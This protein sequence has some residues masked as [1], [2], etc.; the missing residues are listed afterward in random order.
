MVMQVE[1]I[2]IIGCR[3][4]VLSIVTG[5]DEGGGRLKIFFFLLKYGMQVWNA[6]IL[7]SLE[8]M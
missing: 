5:S 1:G 4:Q 6:D 7:G 3:L 2:C 8:P